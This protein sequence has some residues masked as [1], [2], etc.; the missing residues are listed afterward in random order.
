VVVVLVDVLGA[1]LVSVEVDML[2]SVDGADIEVSEV[3]VVS[4]D[5]LDV[6]PPQAAKLS[7]L[8]AAAAA[9]NFFNMLFS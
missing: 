8:A 1:M 7:R 5:V 9:I 6:E 2:V 4:L 3:V